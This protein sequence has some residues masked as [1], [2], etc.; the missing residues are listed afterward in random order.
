MRPVCADALI[1]CGDASDGARK[2][3]AGPLPGIRVLG[4]ISSG[5]PDSRTWN[6]TVA[7]RSIHPFKG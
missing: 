4:Y 5:A 6:I 3:P 1:T 7:H 2:F